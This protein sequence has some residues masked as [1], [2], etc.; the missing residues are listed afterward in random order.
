MQLCTFGIE[1]NQPVATM[2]KRC[3]RQYCTKFIKLKVY[4]LIESVYASAIVTSNVANVINA[5]FCAR[6]HFLSLRFANLFM[7]CNST[8]CTLR[9]RPRLK[10]LCCQNGKRSYRHIQ[11]KS[12]KRLCKLKCIKQY[13]HNCILWFC[14]VSVHGCARA[15]VCTV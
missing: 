10:W 2:D 1:H 3:K 11:R 15:C 8:K 6:D 7:Q 5:V 13:P 9:L 4:C 12:H 14:T